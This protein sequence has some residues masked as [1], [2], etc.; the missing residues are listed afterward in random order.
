VA[1]RLPGFGSIR[2]RRARN[3]RAIDRVAAYLRELDQSDPITDALIVLGRTTGAALDRLEA[4]TESS[5][6]TLGNVARVHLQVLE[7]ARPNMTTTVDAFDRMLDDLSAAV[8]DPSP[9]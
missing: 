9:T 8:R 2:R 6:H 3:E 4:D 1:E 7:A 5:E